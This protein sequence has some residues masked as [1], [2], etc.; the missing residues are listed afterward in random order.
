LISPVGDGGATN[1][2][3]HRANTI[4]LAV[5]H[6]WIASAY[7]DASMNLIFTVGDTNVRITASQ[8]IVYAQNSTSSAYSTQT[9]P[10]T[11]TAGRKFRFAL[12]RIGRL[13]T[14]TYT[15]LVSG[16]QVV[17]TADSSASGIN[18]SDSMTAGRIRG[19]A[20]ASIIAGQALIES[21]RLISKIKR[22][23][24]YVLGDSITNGSQVSIS[25][26]YPTLLDAALG[27]GKIQVTGVNGASSG[28]D[29][30]LQEPAVIKTKP[31]ALF[32]YY[33]TND[34]DAGIVSFRAKTEY[35][36]AIAKAAGI[37]YGVGV[38]A[39]SSNGSV[40]ALNAYLLS[41]PDAKLIRFDLALSTG[42]DGITQNAAM[43]SADLV[44]PNIAGQSA[45]AARVLIDWPELLE[46]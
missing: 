16:Q 2:I 8:M 36:R 11:L 40:A 28:Q 15:D 23:L 42:N 39:A 19:P 24:L 20:V 4:T 44:H 34:L 35:M 5:E 18:N 22:P 45:M 14:F 13:L 1:K 10:V 29:L 7:A 27:G 33:G 17:V 31:R 30:Y 32:S 46:Y 3:T 41:L 43:Y 21:Y 37:P 26:V 25:T 12:K 38:I 9:L 6:E